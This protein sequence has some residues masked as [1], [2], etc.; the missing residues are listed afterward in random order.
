MTAREELERGRAAYTES[1]WTEANEWLSRADRAL[2]WRPYEEALRLLRFD[3]SRTVL[4]QA[5]A[6]NP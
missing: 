6:L 3:D 1:A 2:A 4:T 5:H